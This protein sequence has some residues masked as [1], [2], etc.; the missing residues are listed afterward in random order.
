MDGQAA[1]KGWPRR[2]ALGARRPCAASCPQRTALPMPGGASVRVFVVVQRRPGSVNGSSARAWTRVA[3]WLRHLW[4]IRL[5]VDVLEPGC[6]RFPR[7]AEPWRRDM[8]FWNT[9]ILA[10][11]RLGIAGLSPRAPGTAGS[12]LAALLAPLIFLPLP[13]WGRL[14][15]LAVIVVTGGL[16]ATRAEILLG[17]TDPG[18]VVIDELAG[19]WIALL[20]LGAD[21]WSWPGAAR[22]GLG[23][24][25]VPPVRHLE[26]LA[27]A[28]LGN[29]AARRL[30]HHAGR[31]PG[32]SHGHVLHAGA[33]GPGL[34]LGDRGWARPCGPPGEEGRPFTGA[35]RRDASPPIFPQARFIR[36]GCPEGQMPAGWDVALPEQKIKK[37]AETSFL[38]SVPCDGEEGILLNSLASFDGPYGCGH[39]KGRVCC[40]HPRDATKAHLCQ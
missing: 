14:L 28:R 5:A 4:G 38:F 8:S 17:R 18:E 12:A 30:G 22:P 6:P 32:R 35:E 16:A 2:D 29:L 7:T 3:A 11:C 9:C 24:R 31:Y 40:P 20:P 1:A 37:D 21:Q 25:P 34:G 19:V 23:L 26:A 10:Y 36:R 33:A 13:L 15:F 27:R 39:G